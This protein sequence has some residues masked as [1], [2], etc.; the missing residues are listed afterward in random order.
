MFYQWAFQ[1]NETSKS[2]SSSYT[3]YFNTVKECP[4]CKVVIFKNYGCQTVHCKSC[5]K[6]FEWNDVP[7]ANKFISF[8]PKKTILSYLINSIT[9]YGKL[10]YKAIKNNFYW[11]N[12]YYRR[13]LRNFSRKFLRLITANKY[14]LI[15]G[16]IGIVSIKFLPKNILYWN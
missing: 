4:H 1:Q 15:F 8:A 11:N 5:F 6:F 7:I 13:K 14:K 2:N 12:Y 10:Y 16:L 9:Y 3:S